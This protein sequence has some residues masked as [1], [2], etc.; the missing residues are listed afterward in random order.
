MHLGPYTYMYLR[1]GP[2][3]EELTE[4][5][6]YRETQELYDEPPGSHPSL[7]LPSYTHCMLVTQLVLLIVEINCMIVDGP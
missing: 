4:D 7:L 1:I 3:V 5:Q 2:V 6:E